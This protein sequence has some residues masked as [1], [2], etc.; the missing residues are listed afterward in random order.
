MRIHKTND[1][2]QNFSVITL[3]FH[4]I[5]KY[6]VD[7]QFCFQY[8]QNMT[9][10][11]QFLSNRFKIS[12]FHTF[13]WRKLKK[14]I[15]QLPTGELMQNFVFSGIAKKTP[16]TTTT[17]TSCRPEPT[18]SRSRTWRWARSTP[19]PSW[20]STLSGRPNSPRTSEKWKRKVRKR[21]L[22]VFCETVS[23]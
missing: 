5:S 14:S 13:Q 16:K 6:F 12:K 4:E 17:S 19:S 22:N 11:F 23:C 21:F 8:F 20:P 15:S 18:P 7:F 10:K 3:G 2:S 9:A 1:I